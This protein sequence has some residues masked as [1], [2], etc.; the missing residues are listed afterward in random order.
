MLAG[1]EFQIRASQSTY[2]REELGVNYFTI[3]IVLS[4]GELSQTSTVTIT[5]ESQNDNPH[6]TAQK[7]VMVYNYKGLFD[8]VHLGH[9]YAAD[10]DDW[11]LSEKVFEWVGSHEG[12]R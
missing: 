12:F 7:D 11:D 3:P 5:V 2:D 8:N 4:D 10:E 1:D 9:V 6:K